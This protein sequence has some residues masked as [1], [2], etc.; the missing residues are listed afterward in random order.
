MNFFFDILAKH[1]LLNGCEALPCMCTRKGAV[2]IFKAR[3]SILVS[4][5]G[6]RA[7]IVEEHCEYFDIFSEKYKRL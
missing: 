1:L 2:K 5:K 3:E 4:I 6:Y 7:S